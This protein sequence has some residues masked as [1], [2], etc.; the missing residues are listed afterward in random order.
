MTAERT[1]VGASILVDVINHKLASGEFILGHS[2]EP[3]QGNNL[4]AS[5][6]NAVPEVNE[7]ASKWKLAKAAFEHES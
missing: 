4:E 2:S 5:S 1:G 3:L 6:D 7:N